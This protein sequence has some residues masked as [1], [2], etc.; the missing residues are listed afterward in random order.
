MVFKW[1]ALFSFVGHNANVKIFSQNSL[2]KDFLFI[3]NKSTL[4]SISKSLIE[5]GE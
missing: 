5:F 1:L 4:K 2:M 3:F